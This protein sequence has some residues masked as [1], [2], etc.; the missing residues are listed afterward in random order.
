MNDSETSRIGDLVVRHATTGDLVRS[1]RALGRRRVIDGVEEKL[2]S[3]NGPNHWVSLTCFS[4]DRT[5]PDGYDTWCKDCCR[6][7]R[8]RVAG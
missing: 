3:P 1:R 2:C 5:S 6:A 4:Y 7:H 8:A